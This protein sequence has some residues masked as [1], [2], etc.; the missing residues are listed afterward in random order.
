MDVKICFKC[1]QLKP[2]SEYYK[3]PQMSY[4]YLNKCKI[5]AK[6]D[7]KKHRNNNLEEVRKYDR[8]RANL[9]HR[10]KL[11]KEVEKKWRSDPELK[12]RT[13]ELKRAWQE[14]N[15]I[16][17]A[18]H[19][20]TNNAMQRGKLIKQPCEVCGN[21]KVDAHHDDY[22]KPLDVR[23]LCKKHRAE[24]HKAEREKLR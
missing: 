5:C 17:R 24:H 22:T 8:E 1:N 2:L 11:R 12:K 9:P 6:L 20:I 10:I 4:G 23:W 21:K 16:K 14:K 7:V 15:R 19:I 18:A 3:H 13:S